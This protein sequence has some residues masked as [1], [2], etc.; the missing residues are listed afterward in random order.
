MTASSLAW[1]W[2]RRAPCRAACSAVCG[3]VRGDARAARRPCSPSPC[4]TPAR[5]LQ[6]ANTPVGD[7]KT[8][9]LSGGEKKRLSIATEL[10]SRP[11]LV[12]ADEP[13]SGLDAFAAEKVRWGGGRR[14]GRE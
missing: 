11:A 13:T 3:A 7:A 1:A 5:A 8:R 6:A 9:G 2:Q 4:R 10:I 14:R 12:F